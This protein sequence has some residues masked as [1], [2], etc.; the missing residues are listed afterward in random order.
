MAQ[1]LQC[2]V[3][4]SYVRWIGHNDVKQPT[5]YWRGP[6]AL[7]TAD[8]G[9]ARLPNVFPGDRQGFSADVGGCDVAQW[10]FAGYCNGY[11]ATASSQVQNLP[12]SL[13]R[14]FV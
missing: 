11:R 4:L 8:V 1:R 3:I 7:E 14:N 6:A 5:S 13:A 9:Q 2:L 12:F 10:T